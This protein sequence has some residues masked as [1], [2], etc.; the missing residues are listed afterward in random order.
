M[1]YV[2]PYSSVQLDTRQKPCRKRGHRVVVTG[3]VGVRAGKNL[4]EIV[5][6]SVYLIMARPFSRGGSWSDDFAEGR[7]SC[8]YGV[9]SR[10]GSIY[11]LPGKSSESVQCAMLR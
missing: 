6:R 10:R 1:S 8:M 5:E 4:V 7:G 11:F 2:C 9:S 3:C